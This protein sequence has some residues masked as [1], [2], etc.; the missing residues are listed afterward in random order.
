MRVLCLRHFGLKHFS[1]RNIPTSQLTHTIPESTS[2]EIPSFEGWFETFVFQKDTLQD[3]RIH[4][5]LISESASNE[6]LCLM[7][8]TYVW[9]MFILDS[10]KHSGFPTCWYPKMPWTRVFLFFCLKD[11]Y[12][13][14]GS[15]LCPKV[16][17]MRVLRLRLFCFETNSSYTHTGF[18]TWL[19]PECT[20][21]ESPSFEAFWLKFLF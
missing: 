18:P 14:F 21:N 1:Y 15:C 12:P 13:G 8:G 17:Q 9:N 5:L 20:S 19:I 2:N 10:S 7:W 4:G 16:S 3:S 11:L 6:V